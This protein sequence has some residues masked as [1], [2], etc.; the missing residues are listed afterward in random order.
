MSRFKRTFLTLALLTFTGIS[1]W[2]AALAANAK[3]PNSELIIAQQTDAKTLD[4]S[5]TTDVYSQ[6]LTLQIYDRLFDWTADV[7]LENNLAES[8]KQVD[9]LTLQVK[10][11][12]GVKFHNGDELTAE[13]VK[14]SL[15][16]ASKSG[17]V[18]SFMA[19]VDKVD[20]VDPYTVNIVT[21]K[22][23]GP[24]VGNLAHGSGAILNK[25]YVEG[26]PDK[27]FF[28]P[29]GTGPFRFDSWKAGDRITLK[30]NKEYFRGAPGVDSVVF[31][32][33]PEGTN[34]SIALE[35]KEVDVVFAI[36]PVDTDIV[37][38][39]DYLVL[40]EVPSLSTT[41]I[42]IN[43]NKK[44]LSDLR[45]REAL[46]Y[47]I[48]LQ[49]IADTAYQKAAIV[50]DSFV[51][52]A[53]MGVNKDLKYRKRDVAKAKT[54]LT[55][56]GYKDGLDLK[57]WVNENPARKDAAVIMQDQLKE[58]GINLS[59]ETL[60][61]S[62]YLDRISKGEHDLFI[63]GWPTSPDPNETMYPIFHSSNFGFGGNR[64]FYKNERVDELLDKG[65]ET[66]DID[67]RIP[68]YQEAQKIVYDDLAVLPILYPSDFMGTQKYISGF[69]PTPRSVFLIRNVKKNK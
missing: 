58:V 34:R 27:A 8:Y 16:R 42:G 13:D 31:R 3:N 54:L 59:V 28:E 29:V 53:V 4:P 10:I 50:A 36:Y 21:K 9:P 51:P 11:K 40:H 61:W 47:G 46:A 62:S 24:L 60:E 44:P 6:N 7:K 39:K 26:N 66:L 48:D 63:L 19:I 64:S 2:T 37:R 69:E 41:Y 17:A 57:I 38:S 15:E 67:A 14:F 20:I 65:S 25:K 56:A 30:A 33:I 23:F 49:S 12:K 18:S 1:G 68:L 32:V 22:P 55:E 52:P 45:V 43:F 5:M 35:T